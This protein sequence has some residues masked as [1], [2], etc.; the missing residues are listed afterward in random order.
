MKE[1]AARTDIDSQ[2]IWNSNA[3]CFRD[4]AVLVVQRSTDA[5][6][7]L[8]QARAVHKCLNE[9]ERR[10]NNAL[11]G[12]KLNGEVPQFWKRQVATYRQTLLSRGFPPDTQ[13]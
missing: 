3:F 6:V 7:R 4:A 11:P 1:V 8:K 2:E 5:D 12:R 10:M 13:N 9:F